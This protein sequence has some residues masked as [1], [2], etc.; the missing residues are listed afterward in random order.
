MIVT[1]ACCGAGP[2][3]AAENRL[4]PGTSA[5]AADRK[6]VTKHL[7]RFSSGQMVPRGVTLDE[8]AERHVA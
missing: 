3:V 4:D 6:T 5:S 7:L 2:S 1:F 8:R